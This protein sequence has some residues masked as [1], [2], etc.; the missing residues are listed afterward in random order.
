MKWS[1]NILRSGRKGSG[2]S[3][4]GRILPF[5]LSK[6]SGSRSHVASIDWQISIT[7][8]YHIPVRNYPSGGLA[9]DL[10]CEGI[11]VTQMCEEET[12]DNLL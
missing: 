6:H 12:Y 2:P 10:I 9:G 7:K 11:M 1:K 8:A 4:T 5:H 3:G